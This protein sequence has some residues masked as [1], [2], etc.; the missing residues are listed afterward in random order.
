MNINEEAIEVCRSAEKALRSLMEK[1]IEAREYRVLPTLARIAE[2]LSALGTRINQPLP[3]SPPSAESTERSRFSR[4]SHK[5]APP[6]RDKFRLLKA[7]LP[8]RK[9]MRPAGAGYPRFEREA[10]NLIKV[11]WS[12]TSRTEYEHR[13]PR[14][15]VDALLKAILVRGENGAVFT[16]ENILP[17]P[18][19]IDGTGIPGYQVYLALA[20]L[21]TEGLLQQHGREGYSLFLTSNLERTVGERWEALFDRRSIKEARQ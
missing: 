21:R 2:Q 3:E 7:S 19:P 1:A 8:D 18:D 14:R 15:I 5:H 16:V 10:D 4:K 20:W 6:V 17:V 9:T 11:G 13:A 12:K